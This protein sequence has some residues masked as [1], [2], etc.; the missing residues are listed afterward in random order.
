MRNPP[1]SFRMESAVETP[2]SAQARRRIALTVPTAATVRRVP[3]NQEC[4]G[5]P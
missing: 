5:S 4:G 3:G 1:E 2:F